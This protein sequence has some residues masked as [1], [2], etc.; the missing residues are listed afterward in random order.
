MS[1][2]QHVSEERDKRLGDAE[3]D[4]GECR[5]DDGVDDGHRPNRLDDVRTMA[6]HDALLLI[7]TGW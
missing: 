2:P 4:T 3:D 6:A 5:C 7:F 1:H